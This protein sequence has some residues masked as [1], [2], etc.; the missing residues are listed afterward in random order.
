[1][2]WR[3]IKILRR[4]EDGSLTIEQG[5]LPAPENTESV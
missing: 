1:M 4:V 2:N 5:M 3:T